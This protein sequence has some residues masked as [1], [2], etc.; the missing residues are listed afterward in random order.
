[1]N[2]KQ[3]KQL[4]FLYQEINMIQE[5]INSLQIES[6]AVSASDREWPYCKHTE[7]ITG[8]PSLEDQRKRRK[9]EQRK[10]KCRQQVEQIEAYIYH[11]EDSL[12]RQLLIY[13][14]V[15]GLRWN[16]IAAKMGGG[17][18]ADYLRIM[19]DRFLEK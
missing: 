1:M 9:L 13:R 14:Y 18:S 7:I 17:Y 3:L 16:D 19:L 5:K 11:V 12:I 4:R 15:E 2:K 10:A 8:L 6:A